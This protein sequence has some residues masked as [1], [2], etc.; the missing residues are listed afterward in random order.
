MSARNGSFVQK[1]NRWMPFVLIPAL[2][3]V[4]FGALFARFV[5]YS[6]Y[7]Q[8]SGSMY[9]AIPTGDHFTV[10]RLDRTPARGAVVV[11]HYPEH[12]SQDFD[13]RVIGLPNDVISTK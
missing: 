5:L 10:N 8:P 7:R 2:A 3:L 9:P 1:R 12:P 6:S 11:F 13:K 4:G